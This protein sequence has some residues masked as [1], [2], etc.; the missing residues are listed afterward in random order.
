MVSNASFM[1]WM[2]FLRVLQNV[3]QGFTFKELSLSC[4]H[5]VL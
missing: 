3:L 2:P 4:H 5:R 1:F